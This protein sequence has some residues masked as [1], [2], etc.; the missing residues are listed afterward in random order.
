MR[1]H[2]F[3]NASVYTYEDV[4]DLPLLH[5]TNPD[6]DFEA[7]PTSVMAPAAAKLLVPD[8]DLARPHGHKPPPTVRAVARLSTLN[9]SAALAHLCSEA[10]LPCPDREEPAGA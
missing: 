6:A 8:E 10:D 1:R 9:L 7:I 3:D 2:T 5:S 4:Q